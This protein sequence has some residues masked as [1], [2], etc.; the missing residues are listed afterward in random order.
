M[1]GQQLND[2]P[3]EGIIFGEIGTKI[4]TKTCPGIDMGLA[5]LSELPE[6]LANL[7]K[8]S[9]DVMEPVGFKAVSSGFIVRNGSKYTFIAMHIYDVQERSINQPGAAR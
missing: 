3:L 1:L 2:Q 6:D 5:S 9:A 8:R 7:A 4:R